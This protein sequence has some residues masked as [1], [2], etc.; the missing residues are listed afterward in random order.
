MLDGEASDNEEER[1]YST[2]RVRSVV[3]PGLDYEPIFDFGEA[4]RHD[5]K[6]TLDEQLEPTAA[7]LSELFFP[8]S[9][10]GDWAAASTKYAQ[11]KKPGAP[12]IQPSDVLHFIA[13]VV[14]MGI[15]RLPGKRDYWSHRKLMRSHEVC[16]LHGVTQTKFLYLCANFHLIGPEGGDAEVATQKKKQS[17]MTMK[18]K[19]RGLIEGRHFGKI[20]ARWVFDE[21][22]E[23]KI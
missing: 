8:D 11:S 3:P 21:P 7:T 9:L 5:I 23:I 6:F 15:V 2:P 4:S 17:A 16:T 19:A 18:L 13:I 14:Y 20:R 10:I 12:K 22:V 1:D